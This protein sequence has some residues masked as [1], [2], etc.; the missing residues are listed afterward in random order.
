MCVRL[1]TN[2]LG[3]ALFFLTFSL[4]R[5]LVLDNS[6]IPKI[7]ISATSM[8][9]ITCKK[10]A[11]FIAGVQAI[12]RILKIVRLSLLNQTPKQSPN[13]SIFSF[14]VWKSKCCDK[15]IFSSHNLGEEILNLL[16]MCLCL[17]KD[18]QV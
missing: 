11:T 9:I 15:S 7:T 16:L 17:P 8:Y 3:C 6:A 1:C 18:D 2:G 4:D 13:F 14:S 12:A 5:M 10:K